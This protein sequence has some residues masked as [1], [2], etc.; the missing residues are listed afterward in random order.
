MKIKLYLF[1][2]FL[3][4]CSIL[5]AQISKTINVTAGNLSS[6][7]TNDDLST[8]SNLTITGTIDARDFRFMRDK[9]VYITQLDLSQVKIVAYKGIDGTYD[10]MDIEYPADRIPQYA[11]KPWETAIKLNL[12]TII[13]PT[14]LKSIGMCA[15]D[16]CSNLQSIT[17]PSAIKKIEAASFRD[18]IS[19]KS[20]IIP[21]TVDTIDNMAFSGC[22]GL[23]SIGLPSTLS[24]LGAQAF[25]FCT[26]LTSVTIPSSLKVLGSA[27]A[28]CTGLTQI[29][30]PKTVESLEYGAFE[31]CT[32]LT[33]VTIP[34][35][36][37]KIQGYA[38]SKCTGLTSVIIPSE[39]K[40]IGEYIFS[41]CT[42][43]TN[44]SILSP[45]I[46]TNN[47]MFARCTKVTSL[48]VSW[49]TPPPLLWTIFYM[50]D[51]N[52]CNLQ[53]PYG[54]ANLYKAN[55]EWNQFKSITESSSGLYISATSATV[56]AAE[57]SKA[58]VDITAN[59]DW[60][61][62]SDQ[63]WLAVSPASG[64]TN[65]KLTFT[66]H[67]NTSIGSRTAKVTVTSTGLAPQTIV[68]TQN[69]ADAVLSGVTAGNLKTFFTSGQLKS[70]SYLSLKGII[71]ARDFRLMRDSMPQL[72][73]LDLSQAIIA[74]FDGM[75]GTNDYY[76]TQYPANTIPEYAFCTTTY[77]SKT[78]L[79]TVIFPS[80]LTGFGKYAFNGC[81]NLKSL[82][83]PA[84]VNSIDIGAFIDC[85]SLKSLTIPSGVTKIEESAFMGC[86]GLTSVSL[87]STITTIGMQ[88]FDGCS[89]LT[90]IDIP[91]SI[92]EIKTSTFSNCTGLTSIH[93]PS[94]ITYIADYA[95]YNCTGLT[96]VSLPN[97]ITSIGGAFIKCSGLTSVTLPESVITVGYD[98]F[99]ECNALKSVTIPA[100]VSRIGGNAF[101]YCGSLTS[102]VILSKNVSIEGGAFSSCNNLATVIINSLSATLDNYVFNN[103]TK[104]NSI[105]LA[106]PIPPK[107]GYSSFYQVDRSLCT[108]NVPYGTTP[109]YAAAST[110]KEFL[111]V[112]ELP[113][114]LLSSN[115][116][117]VEAME[118]STA[119]VTISS[120]VDWTITSDQAWLN[121]SPGS[122]NGLDQKLTFTAQA[123]TVSRQRKATITVTAPDIVPQEVVITQ[124]P[125]PIKLEITAGGL[126]SA[127]TVEELNT[128]NDLTIKG[129]ID[130]RDFKTM[131]DK[132]P[133][134][135]RV[136]LSGAKIIEYNGNEGTSN[137][138]GTN[139][140]ANTIPAFAF[141]LN[142][143]G[144]SSLTSIVLPESTIGI[145][146]YAFSQC[147]G[148][149][150]VTIPSQV[151][152]IKEQAFSFCTSLNS[153]TIENSTPPSLSYS[154]NVF[155][156]VNQTLCILNVPFG[157]TTDYQNAYQWKDFIHIAGAP[158]GFY[159][160]GNSINLSGV[161]GS[162]AN[163]FIS[164]NVEWTASSSQ[165]WLTVNPSSGNDS[166]SITFTA[167]E[168]P[169]YIN[170]RSA[171]VTI[172]SPGMKS[173]TVTVIQ[174]SKPQPP[175]TI[176]IVAGGLASALT[177]E[178][179]LTV[180][181][182]TLTGSMDARDFKTMRDRMPLLAKMN[183][184]GITIVAYSGTEGTKGI[185]QTTYP[186]NMIPAYA[187]AKTDGSYHGN[188]TLT[189]IVFPESLEAI[190]P[191]SFAMCYSLTNVI[192]PSS[193]I[194]IDA[195]AFYG[196]TRMS[197]V[198]IPSSVENI[199]LMAF[200]GLSATINVDPA[201]SNYM[202]SN[203][204]LYN[205]AQTKLIQ[206]PTSRNGN[207][208]I[209]S[210]VTTIGDYAFYYCRT[211]TSVTIPSSVTTIGKYAFYYCNGLTTLTIPSSV[212]SIGACAFYSCYGLRT[213][214]A[215]A[216]T[217][218][219]LD[220]SPAAL[221][222][223]YSCTLYVPVGSK[224]AYQTAS[225]WMDFYNIIEINP[226]LIADAGPNQEKDEGTQVTLNG[227]VSVNTS[228]KRVT[229]KW[230]APEGIILSSDTIANPT[231]T[232]P[233]VTY[234]TNFKFSLIISD[235]LNY[236]AADDVYITVRNINKPPVANAG[237]DQAVNE[238]SMVTLDGSASFDPDNDY[239][240]YEWTAPYPIILSSRYA[241]KPTFKSP[242]VSVD[243]KYTFYLS[244]NDGYMYKTDT[245]VI[246]VKQFNQLPVANAGDMQV[247]SEGETVILDG[248]RSSDADGDVLTYKWTAPE[249]I[250]LSSLTSATPSF[251]VPKME[252][253]T[254]L[255]FKLVVNDGKVNSLISQVNIFVRNKLS[256]LHI[257][258]K[259][260]NMETG[261]PVNY[262]LFLYDGNS[263]IQKRDTFAITGDSLHVIIEPGYWIALVSPANDPSAFIPTYSGN[264]LN[265][266]D[267]EIINIPET[268]DGILDI[269][270][271]APQTV[272]AGVG[273]IAG[274]VYEKPDDGTKSISISR[275]EN[276]VTNNP[277]QTALIQLY[278][279]GNAIP[280]A[281]VFT[282]YQG[283]YQFDKLE[284]ADYEIKVEIPGYTQSETFSVVLSD[285]APTIKILF[286]VNT[287]TQVITDNNSI[288]QSIV[289]AYPNPT[290]GIV[291]ISGLPE[292]AK[293][294]VYTVEGKLILKKNS[295]SQDET[296]DITNQV[297]GTYVLLVNEQRFKI[298]KK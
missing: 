106:C 149:T 91:S 152:S 86:R 17:I 26:G 219:N 25:G 186:A 169:S 231:F 75:Y 162:K 225:Q 7:I 82:N 265:W 226:D 163:L 12:S 279:K 6:I 249:G 214:Y 297:S 121:V 93:L 21:S 56:L 218:V 224:T 181:D 282:D 247:V 132:M 70:V 54:T 273:Q 199:G 134:L 170:V 234:Y 68:V 143:V 260:A 227:S 108:L 45:N 173:Q 196:C 48:K 277:V 81:S 168:N 248:R 255:T 51:R 23:T 166:V 157:A 198:N 107:C 11:F 178:E 83:I 293:I 61:A 101:S 18:C 244:V 216:K 72:A 112:K 236:S 174:S 5:Q 287:S 150:K 202:S 57:G 38:F 257:L 46:W 92:T 270:C 269:M 203:S 184:S 127:L 147:I 223:I 29:N 118:G 138:G 183:L 194:N 44:V 2:A 40:I 139:Y 212:T 22:K 161:E 120:N 98:A 266:K 290:S 263:F 289:K 94:T 124:M 111:K 246:T 41:D 254:W 197:S 113:G 59:V 207:F 140:P 206:Y 281:S 110:W 145:G 167:R 34:Q 153:I 3:S 13:F 58:S 222:Q 84:S 179:L 31:G 172:T 39:V 144:K 275:E 158:N 155:Y 146:E 258:A 74:A 235:G 116:A 52:N 16:G 189:N 271:I 19:L 285:T 4:F 264:V 284:I 47:W 20:L 37:T 201:N 36:V 1:I 291:H 283:H 49:T 79:N 15:F 136:D 73:E 180:T 100:S 160:S 87:P 298:F 65:S 232:A 122:G 280:V 77:T 24:Y 133:L 261:I 188:S 148:L 288:K 32:G 42:N 211:L 208:E 88:T 130:A 241:A 53:V 63:T 176:E 286:A 191:Y 292:K 125:A 205:K 262:K 67:Q 78:S 10:Y 272:K 182:L 66:A 50:I 96:T 89:S 200:M 165:D 209:P 27:F 105:T 245:V 97:S 104:L 221:A 159:L 228:G 135:S 117:K 237:K 8:V 240:S 250:T 204:V 238:N 220:A 251:T 33:S 185:E 154:Y 171:N 274:V 30:I 295:S 129:V 119:T 85:S 126:A 233:E 256:Y 175:K 114:Y 115:T 102:V 9:L 242:N 187:V 294:E 28:Y 156:R 217:P 267:A 164:S 141:S 71:D 90:S 55:S 62:T 35:A 229:Y 259:T 123:N 213:L 296:F 69:S 80:T 60:T 268:G 137:W 177:D 151:T 190:G 276:L 128:A 193:V 109:R 215:P 243:T 253:D 95:F 252:S 99:K 103:C 64:T 14:S 43:L 230:T 131:R 239:L 210:T 76:Y 192:I 142:N 278:K 195:Y